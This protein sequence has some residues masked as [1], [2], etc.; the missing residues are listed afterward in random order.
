MQSTTDASNRRINHANV[1]GSG[2]VIKTGS[3]WAL[4]SGTNDYTGTTTVSDGT[5]QVTGEITSSAVTVGANG[6]IL[7]GDNNGDLLNGL[8]IEAGGNLDLNGA[9]IG[10][11]SNK[12]LEIEA[13]SLTLG[14]FT[15]DDIVG[16][17][18]LSAADGTYELI[19]GSFTTDFGSTAFLSEATAYDFGNGQ[20]GY[21]T[22]SNGLNAVVF[23][24]PEPGSLAL[25]GLGGLLIASRRR[26]G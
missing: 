9:T 22:S 15:F 11:T 3:G 12:I 1:T 19:D 23:A 2:S 4:L 24:V 13:G 16:W 14:N 18:W 7:G 25:L 5:L 17:D 20:G 26:R 6:T 8:T 21:F 10:A